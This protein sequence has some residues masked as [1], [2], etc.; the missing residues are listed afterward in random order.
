MEENQGAVTVA[1]EVLVQLVRLTALATPGVAR[2][3]S[4]MPN[5][6]YRLFSGKAAE[7]IQI[8]IEDLTVTIDLYIVAEPDVHMLTLGQMLQR[9]IHRAINDVVG[10]PVKEINIHIEDVANRSIG[11]LAIAQ[12]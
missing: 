6:M 2:L 5:S 8:A 12:T 4:N 7:G 3:Y 9:E 1:P 11:K 10:M